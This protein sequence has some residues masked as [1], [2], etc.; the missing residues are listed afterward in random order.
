MQTLTKAQYE[1]KIAEC[2]GLCVVTDDMLTRTPDLMLCVTCP[3][4]KEVVNAILTGTSISCPK[5]KVT[6]DRQI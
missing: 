3:F 1:Q 4:C 6:V 5:C 2:D